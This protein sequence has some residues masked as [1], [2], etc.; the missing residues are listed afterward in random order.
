[1]AAEELLLEDFDI[2]DA[3][4]YISE[5][6]EKFGFDQNL[7]K[8]LKTLMITDLQAPHLCMLHYQLIIFSV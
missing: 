5:V 1:M 6:C 2:P 3:I 7:Y 4:D 8:H